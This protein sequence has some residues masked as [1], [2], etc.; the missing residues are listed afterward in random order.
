MSGPCYVRLHLCT[1]P[2]ARLEHLKRFPLRR[3]LEV[4]TADRVVV[5]IVL[6]FDGV[7]DD[8]GRAGIEMLLNAIADLLFRAPGDQRV[9]QAITAA[10]F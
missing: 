6:A 7:D 9:N 2:L 1:V 10:V 3:G 5:R 4:I 8:L